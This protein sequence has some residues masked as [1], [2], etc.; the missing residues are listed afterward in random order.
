MV[1]L[2]DGD[3]PDVTVTPGQSR[4]RAASLQSPPPR[5]LPSGPGELH[6]YSADLGGRPLMDPSITA[7]DKR[8]D[9]D[10]AARTERSVSEVDRPGC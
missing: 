5:C 10:P 7:Y 3:M 8:L 2:R 1:G 9:T 6:E 4:V